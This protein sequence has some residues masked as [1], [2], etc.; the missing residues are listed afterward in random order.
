[1]HGLTTFPRMNGLNLIKFPVELTFLQ[2]NH[3]DSYKLFD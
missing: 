1:M 3:G 2:I